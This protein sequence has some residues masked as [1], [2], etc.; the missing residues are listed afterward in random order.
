MHAPSGKL[1]R[2]GVAQ[3]CIHVLPHGHRGSGGCLE[4][5]AT[6]QRRTH[7]LAERDHLSGRKLHGHG[8]GSS[9]ERCI[10]AP[11]A[12]ALHVRLDSPLGRLL[13][14]ASFAAAERCSDGECELI[15]ERLAALAGTPHSRAAGRREIGREIIAEQLCGAL[16]GD[17]D[18][19]EVRAPRA[20]R[21][22]HGQ[23]EQHATFDRPR[24]RIP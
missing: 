12:S 8:R 6:L 7:D 23:V 21:L 13:E 14:A 3:H 9:L 10:R 16:D 5:L 15:Q 19:V 11:L 22:L 20:Q 1:G 2:E 18:V 4:R 24:D 17:G